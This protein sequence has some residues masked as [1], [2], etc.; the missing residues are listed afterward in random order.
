MYGKQR[1]TID[2]KT[3]IIKLFV[4]PDIKK[5]ELLE[6]AKGTEVPEKYRIH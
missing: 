1:I 4:L 2:K 5:F 6:K 3:G